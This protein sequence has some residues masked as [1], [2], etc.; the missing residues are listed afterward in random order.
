MTRDELVHQIY[1][2]KSCLS[3]GLD[4][5]INRIPKHLTEQC[6][7]PVFEFNKQ[8]I[9]HTKDLC[10]CYKMNIAFYESLGVKGWKSLAR[11]LDYLPEN[12]FTI[13]DAKRGDIGNTSRMYAH[14]FFEHYHFDSVTVSPY[15][16]VDSVEPFLGLQGKW[17]ILLALTS[18]AGSQD[19]QHHTDVEGEALYQKVIRVSQSWGG[20]A[21]QM[22]YVVGATH[23][24]N[25]SVIRKSIPY[26]F[27]LI[28]GVGAQGGQVGDVMK[29]AYVNEI[30]GLLINSSRGVIYA[31][32]GKDFARQARESA[33]ILQKEMAEYLG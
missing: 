6:E 30:C 32:N 1:S 5:D 17:V 2:K 20:S 11:T 9:D 18:N 27:L 21:D 29:A 28:P 10:V 8:I 23:P 13:A 24:E 22:M 25:L 19:F 14:T 26:H 16:G 7:D 3:I 33:M 4:V 12:I 15:M 31:G